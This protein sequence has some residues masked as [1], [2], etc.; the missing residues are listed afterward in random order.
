LYAEA[1]PGPTGNTREKQR[2]G[3]KVA[4]GAHL[5]WSSMPVKS[6]DCSR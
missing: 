4:E 2:D 6:R 3:K 1:K 5:P